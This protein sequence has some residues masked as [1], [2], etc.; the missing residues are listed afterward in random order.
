MQILR[1]G[2]ALS[3]TVFGHLS[4]NQLITESF[5]RYCIAR[6]LGSVRMTTLESQRK[7]MWNPKDRSL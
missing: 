1:A 5:R 4:N 7:A 3:A 2:S 6:R